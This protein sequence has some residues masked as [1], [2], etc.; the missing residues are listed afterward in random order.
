MKEIDFDTL[1]K[2]EHYEVPEGYFEQLPG[3]VMGVIRKERHRR[4]TLFI[5]S[6]A[7]VALV[8]ISTTLIVNLPRESELDQQ[9]LAIQEKMTKE[10]Q[11]EAQMADYYAAELA[12]IDYYN[13]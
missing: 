12:Q 6:V 7:A 11:I 9:E 8:I 13:F 1:S 5:T 2:Q 10:E 4:R 3:Q